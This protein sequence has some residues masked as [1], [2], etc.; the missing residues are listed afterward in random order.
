MGGGRSSNISLL[1]AVSICEDIT[2]R[3]MNLEYN[4]T[5]RIG[6]HIWWVSD[7]GKFQSHYPTWGLSYDIKTIIE[8]IMLTQKIVLAA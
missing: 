1:E 3:K 5:N 7:T 2:G 8:E 4:E 6:D